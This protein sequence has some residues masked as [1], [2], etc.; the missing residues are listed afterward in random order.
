[1]RWIQILLVFLVT[2]LLVSAQNETGFNPDEPLTDQVAEWQNEFELP[3]EGFIYPLIL[4]LTITDTEENIILEITEEE[5]IILNESNSIDMDIKL[6]TDTI[7]NISNNQE[8][9]ETIIE[10]VNIESKS[11]K[12][13]AII[14]ALEKKY[15]VTL[16]ENPS[17]WYK[18]V[19]FFVGLFV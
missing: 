8:E 6:T 10:Q 16:V 1:M 3:E 14:G 7:S 13:H 2:S 18:I 11:T 19:R 17:L 5:I 9:L 12:S 4:G 15:E